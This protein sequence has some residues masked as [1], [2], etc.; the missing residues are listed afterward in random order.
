MYLACKLNS[1]QHLISMITALVDYYVKQTINRAH[2]MTILT[3]S[4]LIFVLHK[5]QLVGIKSYH[6]NM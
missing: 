1:L 4:L 6:W 5:S 3:L 2:E